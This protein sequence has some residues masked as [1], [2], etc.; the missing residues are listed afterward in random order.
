MKKQNKKSSIRNW[1]LEN[2]EEFVDEKTGEV[3]CTDMVETWDREV[4]D[5]EQT[6]DGDHIAWSIAVEVAEIF[7]KEKS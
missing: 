2:I 3:D 1:M 7:G 5:G 6:L 4:C